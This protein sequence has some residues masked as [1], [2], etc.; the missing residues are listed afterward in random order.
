MKSFANRFQIGVVPLRPTRTRWRAATARSAGPRCCS[1]ATASTSPP[2]PACRTGTEYLTRV[3]AALAMPPRA[4]P[5][6]GIPVVSA[7]Q[8]RQRLPLNPEATCM[9]PE[10]QTL[11][12]SRRRRA[13]PGH[14][15]RRRNAGLHAHAH[16][17]GHLPAAGAARARGAGRPHAAPRRCSTPCSRRS[18]PR[19]RGEAPRADH[20][21]RRCPP[22]NCALV[23]QVLGEGEVS[24]QVLA[25]P[26][27]REFGESATRCAC[28]CRSRC[29]PACGG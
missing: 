20:A 19:L 26:E 3:A 2:S 15:V 13:R 5:T 25:R 9:T 14:P 22:T 7:A 12:D 27:V 6:I 21:D 8:Q 4:P 29:S 17:H 18:K 23:N 11:P 24:A 28:A 1:S 10:R 16:G